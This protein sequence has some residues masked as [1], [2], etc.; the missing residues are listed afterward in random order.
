MDHEPVIGDLNELLAISERLRLLA[1]V[2]ASYLDELQGHGMDEE[3]AFSLVRDWSQRGFD[4]TMRWVPAPP[5]L[6]LDIPGEPHSTGDPSVA[7][8]DEPYLLPYDEDQAA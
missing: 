7:T 3:Q 8:D 2:Q 6:D 5:V 1:S 4:W